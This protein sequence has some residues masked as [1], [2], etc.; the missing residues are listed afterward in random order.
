MYIPIFIRIEP[1]TYKNPGYTHPPLPPAG[2]EGDVFD[3]P[4]ARRL[5]F[6][7]TVSGN[8]QRWQQVEQLLKEVLPNLPFFRHQAVKQ[9]SSS[10]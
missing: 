1:K 2:D 10:F 3:S 9:Y 7:S 6:I 4:D 5:Q 8:Q